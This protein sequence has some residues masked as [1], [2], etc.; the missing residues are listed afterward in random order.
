M[1]V[2]HLSLALAA[3]RVAPGVN[4][5]YY[6]WSHSLLMSAVW[7]VVLAGV[8]RWRG[9]RTASTLLIALVVSHWVLD[10]ISHAPDMPLWP[11][12][13]PRFGLGLWNSIPLTLIVEGA[14]W[15]LGIWIYLGAIRLATLVCADRMDHYPV[16][17]AG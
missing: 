12:T 2:G 6:P 4:L 15:V 10:Y 3:K 11:G 14:M 8:A 1:F 9:V 7:G 17:G 13:S 5:G 16:G